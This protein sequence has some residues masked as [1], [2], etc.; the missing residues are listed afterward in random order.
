LAKKCRHSREGGNPVYRK[1]IWIAASALPSDET[2]S[3]STKLPN[4]DSQ[5]AGYRNDNGRKNGE[6][7]VLVRQ[8]KKQLGKQS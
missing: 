6:T 8:G 2:T 1:S 7:G 5:V 4:N 3:H